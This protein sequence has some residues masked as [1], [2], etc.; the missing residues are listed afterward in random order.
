[1]QLQSSIFGFGREGCEIVRCD[2]AGFAN[3]HAWKID[4]NSPMLAIKCLHIGTSV[5]N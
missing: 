2:S 3:V 1:M 4:E 5:C